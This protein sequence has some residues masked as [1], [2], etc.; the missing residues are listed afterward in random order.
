MRTLFSRAA[1]N[2]NASIAATLICCVMFGR[3][4]WINHLGST[5]NSMASTTNSVSVSQSF[6]SCV[7]PI[8]NR[9]LI[10]SF[11]NKSVIHNPSQTHPHV[12]I[13]TAS[14][15]RNDDP[16]FIME[17]VKSW[18]SIISQTFSSWTLMQ[19]KNFI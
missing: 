2:P 19:I 5:E 17:K 1:G 12:A 6:P 15:A 13:V 9:S 10:N 3:Y 16:L 18:K 7:Y 8:V 4:F 11:I 14:Y